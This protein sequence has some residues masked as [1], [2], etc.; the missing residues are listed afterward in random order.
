MNSALLLTTL[1]SAMAPQG[2]NDVQGSAPEAERVRVFRYIP[3]REWFGMA[4]N[5]APQQLGSLLGW[6]V[7][8]EPED[9]LNVGDGRSRLVEPD[10]VR[11]LIERSG[12][13][14]DKDQLRVELRGTTLVVTGEP[15]LVRDVESRVRGLTR[16]MIR[17]VELRASLYRMSEA[18][19]L[20][21]V[22]SADQLG[23]IVKGLEPL[24][25]ARAG[26]QAGNSTA[27]ALDRRTAYVADVDVEVAQSSRIGD[28]ITAT[29]L[30]GVRV[31]VQPHSLAGSDDLVVFAQFSVG[32]QRQ[33]VESRGSGNRELPSID[34]PDLNSASGLASARIA[35][36]G[37]MLISLQG[38]PEV[39]LRMLLVLEARA[40]AVRE[41]ATDGMSVYPVS[42]LLSRA[43]T[44][45]IRAGVSEDNDSPG[46]RISANFEGDSSERG[47]TR[48][49]IGYSLREA[50]P[51]LEDESLQV[52]GQHV[53]VSAA[54]ET[55]DAV[56][57]VLAAMQEPAL[58]TARVELVTALARTSATGGVFSRGAGA[59]TDARADVLHRITVP[60][61]LGR[62][63][64]IVRGRETTAISDADVEIAQKSAISNPIVYPMFTGIV[65]TWVVYP[66]LDGIG[67]E[68]DMDL[69]DT[70]AVRR[71]P[72]ETED[73][74][75]LYLPTPTRA[76]F[77]HAGHMTPGSAVRLGAG[78]RVT[79]SGESYATTQWITVTPR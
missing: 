33:E 24:W 23:E 35:P 65:A 10:V 49:S 60:A 63:H 39:G 62:S 15:E 32:E 43:M 48:Q 1:L 76:R 42:A 12:R 64:T 26:C 77:S 47:A 41:S 50:V 40:P 56:G 14:P 55:R 75:D 67:A 6:P 16:S 3:I 22:A 18:R 71:R 53:V 28:P 34:V 30:E 57:K 69:V 73:G 52:I 45:Q 7:D 70:P 13:T 38:R 66:Q 21:A 46:L 61:L 17:H 8:R 29:L 25:S 11:M 51:L 31:T 54:A 27:L 78:P 9:I 68:V 36:G 20:P 72:P 4:N 59:D 5:P 44:Q 2:P 58:Q 74:V 79:L 19:E 37:A